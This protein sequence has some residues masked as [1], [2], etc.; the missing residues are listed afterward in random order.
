MMDQK[1]SPQAYSRAAHMRWLKGDLPGAIELMEVAVGASGKDE[2]A[3]WLQ[4][5]L[6][7]YQLQAGNAERAFV[8]INAALSVQPDS[9]EGKWSR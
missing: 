5:R 7:L 3:L 4:V 1:P 8:L 9:W 2:A 6:A